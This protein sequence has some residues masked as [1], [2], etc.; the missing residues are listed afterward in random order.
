M[1]WIFEERGKKNEEQDAGCPLKLIF[2]AGCIG[3][4]SRQPVS[5]GQTRRKKNYVAVT[6]QLPE[7]DAGRRYVGVRISALR[8]C[9]L[10][11][12]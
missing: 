12:G 1:S 4:V 7:F 10:P 8:F 11:G 2:A 3:H 6:P 9:Q 5:I